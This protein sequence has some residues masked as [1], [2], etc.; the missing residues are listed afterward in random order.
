MRRKW[1]EEAGAYYQYSSP[2]KPKHLKH[3][4]GFYWSC[5]DFKSTD[6]FTEFRWLE[7]DFISEP[8]NRN[9]EAI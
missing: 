1:P 7:K 9:Y 6:K 2:G 4:N 5:Y 8:F 3:Q